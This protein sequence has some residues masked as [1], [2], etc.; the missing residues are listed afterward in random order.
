MNSKDLLLL[1]LRNLLRRKTRTLLA[2][3]GVVVGTCAIIVMLSIGF[4]MSAN[5][6]EQ[7]A[8]Y[9]NLHLVNVYGGGMYGPVM[10]TGDGKPAQL[11]EKDVAYMEKIKEVEAVTPRIEE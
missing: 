8:S 3:T 4:G 6:E 10:D 5:F 2:I 9:G 11:D 1:G 7:I